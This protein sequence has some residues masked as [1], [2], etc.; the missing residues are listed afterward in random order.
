MESFDD[1]PQRHPN[2][3]TAESSESAFEGAIAACAFFSV[4]QRDRHDYGTDM[5]IEARDG[6]AMT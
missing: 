3:D 4:Q 2:H 5:Q 6:V 1:L